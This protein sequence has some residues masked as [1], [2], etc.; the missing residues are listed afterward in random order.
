MALELMPVLNRVVRA[1]LQRRGASSRTLVVQGREVHLLDLPGQGHGPPLVV[2]HGLGSSALAFANILPRLARFS[3]RV[4][5]A[6]LPGSGFS[7]LPP[8]PPNIAQCVE[9]LG[10]LYTRELG[11]VPAVVLGNSLGGAMAAELAFNHPALVRALVL[12]A[13][14]GAR[15]QRERLEALVGSFELKSWRQGRD[16]MRKLYHRPPRLLPELLARDM[17]ANFASPHVRSLLA[18]QPGNEHLDPQK[19]AAL[20]IP[21]LLLWGR[22]ERLLPY[23][24]VD[25]FRAHLPPHAVVEEVEGWGHVPHMDR[26]RELAARVERFVAELPVA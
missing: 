13:P 19:L 10:A 12:S 4:L 25:F 18:L 7:P 16:F 2:L 21:V 8:D 15:L 11:G 6:D 22:S 20:T 3:R 14:A 9:L 23:E 17:I 26:P 24:G 1:Q 5:A